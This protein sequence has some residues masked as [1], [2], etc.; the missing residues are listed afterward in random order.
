VNRKEG[1]KSRVVAYTASGKITIQSPRI[2]T[3]ADF[4]ALSGK[5]YFEKQELP[6][7]VDPAASIMVNFDLCQA[8]EFYEYTVPPLA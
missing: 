5:W 8:V 4:K 7:V 2:V 1:L 3:T 6:L